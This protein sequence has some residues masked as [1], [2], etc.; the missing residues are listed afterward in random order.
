MQHGSHQ[1]N[2]P[3]G[4]WFLHRSLDQYQHE[5]STATVRPGDVLSLPE[6]PRGSSAEPANSR[7]LEQWRKAVTNEDGMGGISISKAC[8]G[9]SQRRGLLRR[10]RR[11]KTEM[12]TCLQGAVPEL[13]HHQGLECS[14]G[15]GGDTTTKLHTVCIPS[16][17]DC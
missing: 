13:R 6:F 2:G 4:R 10:W 5:P 3:A 9:E 1:R 15:V 12:F 17:R 11:L 16:T 7:C 8:L 14:W